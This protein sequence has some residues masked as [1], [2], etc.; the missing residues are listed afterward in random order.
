MYAITA[1]TGQVGGAV[2]RTLLDAGRQVRA[3]LRDPAKAAPWAARGCDVALADVDDSKALARAFEGAEGIFILLPPNFDPAPDLGQTRRTIAALRDALDHAIA[4]RAQPPRI[5]CLSTIGAQATQPNLLNQLGM[6][7]QGLRNVAA[8]LTFLRPAWFMENVQWDLSSAREQGRLASFL[9]P[10]ERP[11]PMV[12]TADVG[13]VAAELLMEDWCGR[14]VVELEG[15]VRLSPLDLAAA[16][17]RLLGKPVRAEAV[18]RAEWQDLF[19]AQ[20]MRHPLPRMQM[21]DGFNQGW[22]AFEGADAPVRKGSTTLD[23]V[24]QALAA[25]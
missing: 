19:A 1:I 12:A 9:Q 16:L 23:N 8:P 15:P 25:R 14:R 5:V 24:L 18:A 13:K 6:L 21:L 2:A 4:G 3:V 17:S 11:L 7:E 20:G 22:I 10:L